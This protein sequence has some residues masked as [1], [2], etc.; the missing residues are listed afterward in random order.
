ML[1]TSALFAWIYLPLVLVGFFAIGRWSEVGAALWL[2]LASLLFYAAWL[3][4]F[5]ALL[6]GSI[7]FNYLV[8]HRIG[9]QQQK[10]TGHE[11]QQINSERRDVLAQVT[12]PHPIAFIVQFFEQ[13]TLQ[14]MNLPQVGL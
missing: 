8:G 7:V 6:V 2:F 14:Q 4:E 11:R 3:P 9:A 10:R 13:F 12:G 5:T 1:F